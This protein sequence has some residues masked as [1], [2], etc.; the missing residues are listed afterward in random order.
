VE[1]LASAARSSEPVNDRSLRFYAAELRAHPSVPVGGAWADRAREIVKE[2]KN[3][4]LQG[5]L[6]YDWVLQ[7]V[8]NAAK[9][10]ANLKASGEGSSEH[11]LK[12]KSGDSADMA[13]L[14]A[15]LARSI[16]LPARIVYGA[17]VPSPLPAGEMREVTGRHCWVEV[18]AL[19]IGWIPVDPALGD[20]QADRARRDYYFGNL[21]ARHVTLSQGRELSL[22]PAQEGEA[23]DSLWS[24][25]VEVDGKPHAGWDRKL[26]VSGQ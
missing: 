9:D 13:A 7:Q 16:N 26:A 3:P 12:T 22:S 24:V 2:E 14:Y 15:S 6:L 19:G 11:A 5:R 18:F 21:D 4:V 25:Y 8:E 10:P 20:L 23:V 1:D 17:Q